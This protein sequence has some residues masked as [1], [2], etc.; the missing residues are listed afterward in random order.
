M[1]EKIPLRTAMREAFP[2]LTVP[3]ELRAWAEAS[4]AEFNPV[5]ATAAEVSTEVVSHERG[6]VAGGS[7]RLHEQRG[8]VG[9]WPQR[10]LYAAG[11]ILA[12]ALGWGVRGRVAWNF[13][14]R[15]TASTA[16]AASTSAL[17]SE[18]VDNHIRSLMGDHLMDVRSTD[19]HTV[20]PWFA[21]RTDFAPRVIDLAPEG[22]PLLGGRLEYAQGHAIA[23]LVFGR[24]RHTINLYEWPVTV[25]T[26]I[27]EAPRAIKGFSVL[28][29]V[30][31]GLSYWAVT[32]ASSADLIELRREY[33][34]PQ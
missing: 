22:F 4:A 28:H 32:D 11:L 31:D 13:A 14:E 19:E 10:L 23:A 33:I 24:R 29:W 6:D 12:C 18:L 26:D 25:S 9:R 15:S 8:M 3:D 5:E 16:G 17:A 21:G 1:S 34:A 27:A 2:E 20:K 7:V 30:W